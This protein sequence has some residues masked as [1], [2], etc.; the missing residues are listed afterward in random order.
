MIHQQKQN[1]F[2]TQKKFIIEVQRSVA[3]TPKNCFFYA[4]FVSGKKFQRTFFASFFMENGKPLQ[5]SFH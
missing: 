4:F 2:F 3:K 5:R 1:K